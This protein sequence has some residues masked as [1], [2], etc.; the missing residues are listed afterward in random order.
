MSYNSCEPPD[1]L[2]APSVCREGIALMKTGVVAVGMVAQGFDGASEDRLHLKYIHI[3]I[4]YLKMNVQLK[5]F[6]SFYKQKEQTQIALS[7]DEMVQICKDQ[8]YVI[9]LEGA[10]KTCKQESK[11][12][13]HL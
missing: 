9:M 12:P 11:R 4:H 6:F 2:P 7:A 10:S 1:P 8:H 13:T 3:L 5:R